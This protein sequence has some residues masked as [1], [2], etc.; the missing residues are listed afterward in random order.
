[1]KRKKKPQLNE[2]EMQEHIRRMALFRVMSSTNTLVS[3]ASYGNTTTFGGERDVYDTLGYP[4]LDKIHFEDYYIKYRRQDI[5]SK[6]VE[7]P[8]E[9]SWRVLPIVS[10][11]GED[12][13]VFKNAWEELEKKLGIYNML[14][15]ADKCA[16]IG[17]FGT[18]L[19]GFN[20]PA[21]TLDKPIQ[22]ANKLLYLQPY[23]EVNSEIK[24][25]IQDKNDER[26]GLPEYYS[27]RTASFYGEQSS[28]H[29]QVHHSRII[30]IAENLLESNVYGMPPLERVYNRLLNLEL[31]VGGSAE[32]FWQGA[33][34]GLVFLADEEAEFDDDDKATFEEEIQ[35]YVHKLERYMKLRGVNVKALAPNV[36]DPT[37][38]IDVQIK[39]ISIAS[40]I[41][42]RIL[43]GSERGELA[44]SQDNELWDDQCDGR[45]RQFIEP[46]ILRPTIER[47]IEVGV[48]PEPKEGISIEWPD[49]S[50]PS[51]KDKAETGRIRA[52]AL[53]KYLSSPD[54]QLSMPLKQFL[55][56]IM[57][58]TEER[59]ERIIAETELEMSRM[60]EDDG[61]DDDQFV[62]EDEDG[63]LA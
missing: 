48:L 14:I 35:K 16:R 10:A 53:S 45:R 46:G 28:T 30:H 42:K 12:N 61:Q 36:A 47:L 52:E 57:D 34:P 4:S 23:T 56:E 3:R 5:A 31:I 43:E 24:N 33:F 21:E 17:R 40:G 7:K 1:M 49:L 20:D 27:L 25:Y 8:V 26:Y 58:M 62:E 51:D 29:T 19:L 2:R 59:V 15:R 60:V 38:H 13:D 41:P 32:M 50:A 54:A 22:S 11:W 18:L 9:G 39:M 6:V 44:S 37:S 63:S 55:L